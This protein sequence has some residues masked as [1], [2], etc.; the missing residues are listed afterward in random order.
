V[1]TATVAAIAA[2][3]VTGGLVGAAVA[4]T[5]DALWT[6]PGVTCDTSQLFVPL[7]ALGTAGY[8]IAT[9]KRRPSRGQ[10]ALFALSF[11]GWVLAV[12]TSC[13]LG[14]FLCE[15]LTPGALHLDVYARE[16]GARLVASICIAVSSG[17]ALA[18]ASWWLGGRA[19]RA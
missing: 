16:V 4:A 6:S 9:K 12:A 8:A 11:S 18:A 17:A 15:A 3:L 2:A 14:R 13:A 19:A 5:C 10:L 1:R 7:F